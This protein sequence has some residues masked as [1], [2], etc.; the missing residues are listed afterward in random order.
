MLLRSQSIY[1]STLS[2]LSGLN[3]NHIEPLEQWLQEI[4]IAK[5]WLAQDSNLRPL[6]VV[7][8]SSGYPKAAGSNPMR[9]QF[10]A[11]LISCSRCSDGSMSG[12]P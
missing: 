12:Y 10:F 2:V 3:G 6:E 9:G 5:N 4:S 8:F 11:M 1:I 7:S